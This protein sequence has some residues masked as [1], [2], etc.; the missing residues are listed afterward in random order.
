MPSLQVEMKLHRIPLTTKETKADLVAKLTGRGIH[1]NASFQPRRLL[2]VP[3]ENRLNIW[4]LLQHE[5]IHI[6]SCDDATIFRP[7]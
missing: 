1:H 3:A 7:G 4:R 5:V 6:T 2:H